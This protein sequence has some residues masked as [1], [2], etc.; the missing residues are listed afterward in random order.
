MAL[1]SGQA[2]AV[3]YG[4]SWAVMMSLGHWLGLWAIPVGLVIMAVV[5][6]ISDWVVARDTAALL[7][8]LQLQQRREPPR[9][10][11]PED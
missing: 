4:G 8:H 5:W 10:L 7:R 1:S 9:I 3:A 11:D 6:V 2:R